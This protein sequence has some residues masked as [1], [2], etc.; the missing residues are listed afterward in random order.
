MYGKHM[1]TFK[2][3]QEIEVIVRKI[4][5]DL[6]KHLPSKDDFFTRMD[7]L[8]GEIQAVRDSQELHQGQHSEITDRLDRH[9]K[10]LS[11]LETSAKLPVSIDD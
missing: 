6:T 10:R 9:H 2:D 7:K 1:L 8:S 5:S 4:V 11:T 3:L